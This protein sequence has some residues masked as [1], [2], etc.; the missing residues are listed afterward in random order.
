MTQAVHLVLVPD[1]TAQTFLWC[2]KRFT[3]R[4]G[5][6]VEVISDNTKTFV[7]MAQ[8]IEQLFE[9]KEVQQYLKVKV[10]VQFRKKHPGGVGFL[11]V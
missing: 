11:N 9:S 8:T 3:S 10:E 7:S 6:L 4:R 5:I 2:F 1:L